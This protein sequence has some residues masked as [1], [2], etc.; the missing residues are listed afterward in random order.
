MRDYILRRLF[1]SAIIAW[2][3]FTITFILLRLGPTSPADK[4]LANISARGAQNVSE[5]VAAIEARYGLDKPLW[6]QYIDYV[7]NLVKGNWGWS[8]ST[9]MPVTEL[10]KRHWIYSF[11]L[12]FLSFIF[13]ASLGMLIGLYSAVKK[14]T[15]T[16]YIANFFSFVGNSITNFWL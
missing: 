15:K 9:S 2:G 6:Q 16:D 14:Y 10:I 5:V 12:V 13:S 4:Y 1:Y 11:Q 3:V 8:L 7:L